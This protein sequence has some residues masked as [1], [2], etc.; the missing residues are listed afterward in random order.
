[1]PKKVEVSFTEKEMEKLTA[2]FPEEKALK[3]FIKKVSIAAVSTIIGPSNK[4]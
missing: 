3:N 4:K 1:M 2:V